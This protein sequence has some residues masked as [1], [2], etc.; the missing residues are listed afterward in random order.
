MEDVRYWN[1]SAKD[2]DELHLQVNE[3]LTAM[4]IRSIVASLFPVGT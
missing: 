3:L 1:G 2:A 4:Q